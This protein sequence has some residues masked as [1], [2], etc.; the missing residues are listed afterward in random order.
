[1]M[2]R[3][4]A[5]ISGITTDQWMS[6]LIPVELVRHIHLNPLRAKLVEDMKG[7][8]NCPYGGHSGLMD[9]Q[10]FMLLGDE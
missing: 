8:D 5:Q 4:E 9:T 10:S 3:I 2:T 1:M 7:L 6:F